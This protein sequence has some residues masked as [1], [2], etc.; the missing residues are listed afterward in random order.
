MGSAQSSLVDQAS[1]PSRHHRNVSK[2]Y[3]ALALHASLKDILVP[4]LVAFHRIPSETPGWSVFSFLGRDLGRC[5]V[6]VRGPG[7][8]VRQR[9]T[10]LL[11]VL[12]TPWVGL[13]NDA[14]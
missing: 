12:D 7:S 4:A 6:L 11:R 2:P 8:G 3:R 5:R 10:T 9:Q 14:I 1:K 13:V